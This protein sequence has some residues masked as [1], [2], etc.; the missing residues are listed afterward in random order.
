MHLS[1]ELSLNLHQRAKEDLRR[2]QLQQELE[3]THASRENK[4]QRAF[5]TALGMQHSAAEEADALKAELDQTTLSTQ[6]EIDA[7]MHQVGNRVNM[8]TLGTINFR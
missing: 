5:A 1:Y 2:Q 7:L 3:L 4:A 8:T 6:S